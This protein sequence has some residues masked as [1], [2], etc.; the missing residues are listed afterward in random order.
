MKF[1]IKKHKKTSHKGDNGRVLIIGGSKDYVGALAL[2][3]LA[4]MR[5]GCDWVTVAAPQKVAWAVNCLSADLVT[6]KVKGDYFTAKHVKEILA[7]AKNFDAVLIGNGLGTRE[8]TKK[9]VKNVVK[10]I[11]KPLVIDADAIKALGIKDIKNSI[12]TPHK[13]ELNIFLKNSR[14]KTRKELQKKLNSNVV[15][16]KGPVDLIITKSTVYYNRTGNEGM[17]KAGTGDVLAGL[18]AGF[19]SQGYTS[20][21]SAV[22]SAYINGKTGDLLLKKKKGYTFL[23]SDIVEDIKK[24]M[25]NS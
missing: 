9:F 22:N 16:L 12:I 11:N 23:A 6:K 21:Q 5:S 3:G 10:R 7:L 24:V 17:T 19:V 2:A 1:R 8:T 18:C 4:A 20:V 15:L 25:E 13:G 14:I